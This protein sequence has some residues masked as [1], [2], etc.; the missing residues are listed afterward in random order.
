MLVLLKALGVRVHR[1]VVVEY[2]ELAAQLILRH[3]QLS[4]S[5]GTRLSDANVVDRGACLNAFYVLNQ[6]LVVLQALN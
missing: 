4:L 3:L 2:E 5:E 1:V 6:Y